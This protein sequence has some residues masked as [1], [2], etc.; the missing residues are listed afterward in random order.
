MESLVL[1]VVGKGLGLPALSSFEG[2]VHEQNRFFALHKREELGSLQVSLVE[3]KTRK[4]MLLLKAKLHTSK[5]KKEIVSV[6]LLQHVCNPVNWFPWGQEA[7]RYLSRNLWK[8][9]LSKN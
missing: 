6:V 7:F 8:R 3:G 1:L 9:K 4:R 2:G 5:L